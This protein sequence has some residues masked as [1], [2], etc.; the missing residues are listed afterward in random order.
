M[1]NR[2]SII[3]LFIIVTQSIFNSSVAYALAN[4]IV[5]VSSSTGNDYNKGDTP[6]CPV[7][8]IK[9]ALSF[10]TDTIKLKR[11][12]VFHESIT[13]CRSSIIGY[14]DGSL[15]V[16]SGYKRIVQPSWVKVRDNI[17]KLCLTDDIFTGYRVEGSSFLNNIGCIH[18]YD[19]DL[20][21]GKRIERIEHLKDDWD[22]WQC[23]GHGRD[24]PASSFDYIYMYLSSNPNQKK[25]ELSLNVC[26]IN[27]YEGHNLVNSIRLEGFNTA[28]NFNMAGDIT[29]CRIDAIGGNL[30]LSD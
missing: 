5:Y 8:T 22:F 3:L 13:Y 30:F 15:P 14:G 28:V 7:Q 19:R 6:D 21:H 17:W 20:V 2:I 1:K 27:M 23:E 16:L 12:D 9:K 10:R 29:N 4:K 25:L 18:E 26:G 24:L 11:G